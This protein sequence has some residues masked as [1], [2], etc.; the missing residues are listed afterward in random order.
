MKLPPITPI[1]WPN[2]TTP[3]AAKATITGH[4]TFATDVIPS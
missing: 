1:P 3:T 4:L 2:Q